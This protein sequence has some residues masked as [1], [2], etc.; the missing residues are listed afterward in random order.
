MRKRSLA[1]F[2]CILTLGGML[3]A[4]PWATITYAEGKTFMLVR[5]G[6]TTSFS[7]TANDIFGMEIL[8]GDILQTAAATYLELNITSISA[9]IQVAEN[10][11]FKCDSD[12][13][14]NQVS[15]ELYYGRV[16]AKV[17]KLAGTSSFKIT[18]PTLVAGVRGTDFGCDVIALRGSKTAAGAVGSSAPGAVASSMT[19]V[20]NRVFCFEGSVAVT[21]SVEAVKTA[22]T[23]NVPVPQPVLLIKNEMV[24]NVVADASAPLSAEPLKKNPISTEVTGFWED[25]PFAESLPAAPVPAVAAASSSAGVFPHA[26]P[27]LRDEKPSVRNLKV[28]AFAAAALIVI[29]SATCAGAALYSANVDSD[30]PAVTPL[31]SAGLIMAGSGSILTLLS[32]LFD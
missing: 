7:A 19:P 14:G 30:A 11:S 15:G 9:A 31:F 26:W 4:S 21:P 28:P 25:K 22:A 2:V 6:K 29:G 3:Q 13:T 20:L 23:A 16:R 27:P 12:K 1:L 8:Q 5:A 24:E 32:T 10:T 17:A 18:T